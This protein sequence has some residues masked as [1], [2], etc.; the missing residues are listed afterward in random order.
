MPTCVFINLDAATARRAAVEA[1]FAAAAPAGWRLERFA[2]IGGPEAAALP[3]KL[4]PAQKGCFASHRAAL[5][6]HLEDEA[7]LLILEDDALV[8]A[9]TFAV[10]EEM[11]GRNH[12]WDALF[13][14]L[15]LVDPALMV[16]LAKQR[17]D[18][19]ARGAHIAV[20]L[21]QRAFG[22]STAYLVRGSAKRKL[23]VALSRAQSL[24]RPYDLFLRELCNAGAVSL[25]MC[26]PFV[27]RLA[28][29]ADSS[30]IADG[31]ALFDR[32]LNAFRRLMAAERDVGECEREIAALPLGEANDT[33]RL[34][35]AVFAAMLSPTFPTNL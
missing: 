16:R 10:A 12:D 4:R 24:D 7:P 11:L 22:G 26:F 31:P 13:T 19:V 3:G 18:M 8:S 29:S 32:T 28:P 2:A 34:T 30:Q 5:A 23:H 17:D 33:A 6:E 27:T 9:R 20:D 15:A 1:A 25:G 14:D 21:R 35:G